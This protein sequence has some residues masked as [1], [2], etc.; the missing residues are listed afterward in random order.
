MEGPSSKAPSTTRL[1]VGSIPG[2]ATR[3]QI[4]EYFSRF[5]ALKKVEMRTT[6][7]NNSSR[8]TNPGHCIV[9]VSSASTAARILSVK[10]Y[11]AGR[12]LNCQP[13]VS[14]N[15]RKR[16]DKEN[17]MRRV[18]LKAVP[19]YVSRDSLWNYA[20]SFGEVDYLFEFSS[21]SKDVVQNWH[22]KKLGRSYSLQF[23]SREAAVKMLELKHLFVD[24]ARIKVQQ[25]NHKSKHQSDEGSIQLNQE[26][27]NSD[28]AGQESKMKANQQIKDRSGG[29][30]KSHT[31]KVVKLHRS[32]IGHP[33]SDA[34][35]LHIDHKP[36]SRKYH[37]FIS[38]NPAE[39][40][41]PRPQSSN[42]RFNLLKKIDDDA[43]M[44]S[45]A[46]RTVGYV[47]GQDGL[48]HHDLI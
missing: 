4:K 47:L 22:E 15:L 17:N 21:K 34:C 24:G 14:G 46:R 6:F 29:Q 41:R 48:G 27:I 45:F 19:P 42:F 9:V 43:G 44:S 33:E 20:R 23:A 38:R 13:Y 5:G 16:L 30:H 2:E 40:Q 3:N 11:F 1:Y 25:Y 37:N 31:V 39:E 36:T 35:H 10:H 26:F 7:K 8:E 32:S 18:V 28:D 12:K